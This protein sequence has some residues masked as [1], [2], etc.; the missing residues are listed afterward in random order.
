MLLPKV[1]SCAKSTLTGDGCGRKRISVGHQSCHTKFGVFSGALS[2][3]FGRGQIRVALRLL[4]LFSVA[5]SA[6][7]QSM[8]VLHRKS[9]H[10]VGQTTRHEMA[11]VDQDTP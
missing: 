7:S 10:P 8:I 1:K 4:L 9:A 11:N 3:C 2:H 5:L 6:P